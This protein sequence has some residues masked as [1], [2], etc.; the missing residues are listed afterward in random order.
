MALFSE[1]DYKITLPRSSNLIRINQKLSN[2]G[3]RRILI[4]SGSVVKRND[5]FSLAY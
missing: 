4:Y 2:G 1:C 5:L 3:Q